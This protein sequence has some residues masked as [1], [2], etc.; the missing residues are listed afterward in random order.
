MH[1]LLNIGIAILTLEKYFFSSNFLGVY[2]TKG[3]LNFKQI[4]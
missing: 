1:E 2:A 4:R 3:I